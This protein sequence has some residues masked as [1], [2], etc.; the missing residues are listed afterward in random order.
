MIY[1]MRAH[2]R[3]LV[4][5]VA[6]TEV[7]THSGDSVRACVRVYVREGYT[8]SSYTHW[9]IQQVAKEG[10]TN[11]ANNYHKYVPYFCGQRKGGR[12]RRL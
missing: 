5:R 10:Y 2:S 11:R 8:L 6:R 12:S 4:S 1:L 7:C 9:W 3:K